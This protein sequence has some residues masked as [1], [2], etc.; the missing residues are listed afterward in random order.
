MM[1]IPTM[2]SNILR[3]SFKE[4]GTPIYMEQSV[5]KTLQTAFFSRYPGVF[6][7]HN[8]ASSKLV[9]DARLSSASGQ[10]RLFFGRR[11]GPDIHE[12]VKKFLAHEPQSNT[13]WATNMAML[14]LWNDPDNRRPDGSLVIEPLHQVHDALCGQ[15]PWTARTGL[16]AKIRSYFNNT[17]RIAD[18]DVLIPLRRQLR[19]QLGQ[20]SQ[21]TMKRIPSR[22]DLSARHVP[23]RG[24]VTTTYE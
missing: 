11:F 20:P 2:C 3:D 15:F 4:S 17:L 5:A 16:S 7:W 10:S 18:R 6:T 9:A 13:T 23:A 1:G 21:Q 14:N 8:W 12:T 19:S 24:H 22:E